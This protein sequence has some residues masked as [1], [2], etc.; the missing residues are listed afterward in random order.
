[1]GRKSTITELARELRKN[2]TKSEKILWEYLRKR[3][4]E[5]LRFLRQYPI[6]HEERD[7]ELFF[8]IADF[9]C[10]EVKM[11]LEIDGKIHDYQKESDF[12]RDFVMRRMG[13]K[14]LRIKNEE[15]YNIDAVLNKI[16]AVVEIG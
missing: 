4:F 16:R 6:I 11:V 13:L 5:G 1:M 10:S 15:L 8:Y 7:R 12:N 9:Y 14:V 3:R 2:S